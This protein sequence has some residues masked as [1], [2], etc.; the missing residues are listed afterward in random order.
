MLTRV[1]E[2]LEKPAACPD[3]LF[4]ILQTCWTTDPKG[5]CKRFCLILT[6]VPLA[7][8]KQTLF[9][10]LTFVETFTQIYQYITVNYPSVIPLPS[11]DSS[12]DHTPDENSE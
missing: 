2:R 11:V 3:M 9:A 8:I 5:T 4:D 10:L 7:K 1:G 12:E 6:G